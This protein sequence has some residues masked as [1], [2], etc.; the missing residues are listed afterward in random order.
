MAMI[1]MLLTLRSGCRDVVSILYSSEDG[2]NLER[3]LIARHTSQGP[4][5]QLGRFPSPALHVDSTVGLFY[6]F[7]IASV[8][9]AYPFVSL[10]LT[11]SFLFPAWA[12]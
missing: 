12:S 10:C 6:C 9:L 4:P 11:L 2:L 5:T 1:L 7:L 3:R 8:L